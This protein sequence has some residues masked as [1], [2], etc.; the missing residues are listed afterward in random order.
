MPGYLVSQQI[1]TLIDQGVIEE[2]DLEKCL[3]PASYELRV[4]S[5]LPSERL[6]AITLSVGEAVVVQPGEVLPVGTFEKVNL[7]EDIL[8]FLY[9]RS[10][11][12]RRGL[13]PWS[14]G[15][16]EPGYRGALTIVIHNHSKNYLPIVGGQRI[17]HLMFSTAAEKTEQPY[18]D[19]YQGSATATAAKGEGSGILKVVGTLAKEGIESV[20]EGITKGIMG[21]T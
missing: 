15:I 7:P 11:Y 20:A 9:L 5:Y 6:D 18:R 14:Q 2:A 12:A 1:R 4:G 19:I 21:S 10:S 17:T 3:G 8:G 13:L 16:V